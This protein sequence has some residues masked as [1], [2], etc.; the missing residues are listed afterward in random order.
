MTAFEI[1]TICISSVGLMIAL[2][3]AIAGKDQK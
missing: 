3:K 2:I 1:V